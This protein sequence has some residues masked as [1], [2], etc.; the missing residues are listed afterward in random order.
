MWYLNL[1]FWKRL[2]APRYPR[3][4]TFGKES[5]KA[6]LWDCR[7]FE[8][9]L[10][11]KFYL[12]FIFNFC[13]LFLIIIKNAHGNS[14]GGFEHVN[15]DPYGICSHASQLF[16]LREFRKSL[17]KERFT[18]AASGKCPRSSR[19]RLTFWKRSRGHAE[20]SI[21]E[22]ITEYGSSCRERRIFT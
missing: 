13:V 19:R 2:R 22:C 4:L 16:R 18:R 1:K 21:D 6:L 5:E 9:R 14:F 15:D 10:L 17:I 20:E 3:G 7:E 11:P 12:T 8:Y